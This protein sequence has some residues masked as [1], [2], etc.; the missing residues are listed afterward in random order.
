ALA[1]R[2]EQAPPAVRWTPSSAFGL[3]ARR[4]PA[5][6]ASGERASGVRVAAVACV[7]LR[8]D[9]HVLAHGGQKTS[10]QWAAIGRRLAIHRSADRPPG[11]LLGLCH[12]FILTLAALAEA[13]YHLTQAHFRRCR[14]QN[15]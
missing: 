11:C 4:E 1:Q 10:A 14:Y 7:A 15:G 5:G 3:L 12:R 9:Q 2:A 6:L 8:R 13:R